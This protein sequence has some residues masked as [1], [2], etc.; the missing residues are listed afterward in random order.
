MDEGYTAVRTV[1]D[2]Y[3][4]KGKYGSWL[5]DAIKA[6][7]LLARKLRSAYISSW[8]NGRKDMG[9]HRGNGKDTGRKWTVVWLRDIA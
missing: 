9:L 2:I 3:H 7:R 6:K 4:Y 1:S 5:L 8:N